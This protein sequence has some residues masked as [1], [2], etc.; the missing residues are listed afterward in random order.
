MCNFVSWKEKDGDVFYLT[1]KDLKPKKF[2][3]FKEY[4]SNWRDD[5]KGHGAIDWFYPKLKGKCIN[6]ECDDFFS[7]KNFPKEIVKSI[8]NMELTKIGF[9]LGLINK[10]GIKEYQKIEKPAWEEYKKI[11]QSLWEEYQKIIQSARE[12]YEKIVQ[13]AFWKVFAQKK[14]RLKEWI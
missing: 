7:P 2:K 13:P 1:D 4:N 6:R 5:L 12:E 11:R 8:K 10:E 9:N 14:Y 3:E